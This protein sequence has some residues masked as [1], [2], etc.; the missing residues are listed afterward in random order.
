MVML[1]GEKSG[2]DQSELKNPWSQSA[3]LTIPDV[4]GIKTIHSV[5]KNK[6]Y[7]K[8]SNHAKGMS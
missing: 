7:N 2:L 6:K 3:A 4:E 8:N 5:K 1:D